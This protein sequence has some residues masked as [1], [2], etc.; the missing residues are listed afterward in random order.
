METE[1]D[2]IEQKRDLGADFLCDDHDEN[3]N[4]AGGDFVGEG[5]E[6]DETFEEAEELIVNVSGRGQ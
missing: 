5:G 1:F 6:R 2:L 4:E 3:R